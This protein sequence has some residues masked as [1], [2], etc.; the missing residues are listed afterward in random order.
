MAATIVV[1]DGT[2]GDPTAN[3]YISLNDANTYLESIGQQDVPAWVNASTAQKIA[4][5]IAGQVY[6]DDT[7]RTR[8]LG[9]PA[10][11]T[12]DTQPLEFPRDGLCAPSGA[13][14]PSDE[15]PPEIGQAQTHLAIQAVIQPLDLQPV[16]DATGR[17]V[18]RKLVR[19]EGAVTKDTEYDGGT[20]PT[21]RRKYPAAERVLRKWLMPTSRLLLRA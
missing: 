6:M 8:Y 1:E 7:Y 16:Y 3:S 5:L 21:T 9:A 20:N 19:V 12:Q 13:E 2:G 18:K 4:A 11:A 14:I 15:I 17:S 10:L